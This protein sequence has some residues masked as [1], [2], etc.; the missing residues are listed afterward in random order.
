MLGQIVR[1]K[2][3]TLIRV[4]AS[5]LESK[6]TTKAI[7]ALSLL[8]TR[9]LDHFTWD[10]EVVIFV[11]KTKGIHVGLRNTWDQSCLNFDIGSGGKVVTTTTYLGV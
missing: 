5:E 3:L 11:T 8:C 10:G 9:L 6:P 4:E 7:D 2:F 1:D